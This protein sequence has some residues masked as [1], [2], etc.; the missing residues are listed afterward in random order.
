MRGLLIVELKTKGIQEGKKKNK[1]SLLSIIVAE[2][3][4]PGHRVSS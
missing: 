4:L 2:V 3:W 1:S